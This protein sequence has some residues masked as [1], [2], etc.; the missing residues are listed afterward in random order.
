METKVF[1]SFQDLAIEILKGI[2]ETTDARKLESENPIRLP[3]QYAEK[4]NRI[5]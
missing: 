2:S 5:H 4:G 3:T 1:H